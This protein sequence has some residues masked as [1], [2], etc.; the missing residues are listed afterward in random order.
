MGERQAQANE[1]TSALGAELVSESARRVTIG[2]IF[3]PTGFCSVFWAFFAKFYSWLQVCV[4][5]R[6]V[7]M[8]GK[9][10][11][12]ELQLFFAQGES[13]ILWEFCLD[14]LETHKNLLGFC[15]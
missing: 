8:R 14:R 3:G 10:R 6:S 11:G 5:P 2:V 12:T 9:Q 13:E 15:M 4:V 1:L 7:L